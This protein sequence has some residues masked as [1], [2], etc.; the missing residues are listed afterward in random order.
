MTPKTHAK[1]TSVHFRAVQI[2]GGKASRT[3]VW[4]TMAYKSMDNKCTRER[5]STEGIPKRVDLIR[6]DGLRWNRTEGKR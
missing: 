6:E 3:C 4:E 5:I 2:I 1:G